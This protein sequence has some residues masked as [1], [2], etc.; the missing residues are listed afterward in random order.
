M[1]E[2]LDPWHIRHGKYC[3]AYVQQPRS[4]F[5]RLILYMRGWR[6]THWTWWSKPNRA[7]RERG[8]A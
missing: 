3:R 6:H 8:D 5:V 2:K 4:I 1:R 7:A